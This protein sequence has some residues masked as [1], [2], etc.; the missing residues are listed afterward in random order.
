LWAHVWTMS[1]QNVICHTKI[2]QFHCD[3]RTLWR[4]Y[5]TVKLAWLTERKI[6]CMIPLKDRLN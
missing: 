5:F 2:G 1:Y 3:G 4:L 6:L